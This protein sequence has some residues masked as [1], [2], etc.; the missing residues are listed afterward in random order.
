M[1]VAEGGLTMAAA[2]AVA[3]SSLPNV[4]DNAVRKSKGKG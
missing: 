3:A 1:K 4:F 2:S